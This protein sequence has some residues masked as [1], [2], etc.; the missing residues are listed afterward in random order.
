MSTWFY[1]W[2]S[3]QHYRL[4]FPEKMFGNGGIFTIQRLPSVFAPESGF[5]HEWDAGSLADRFLKKFLFRNDVS[6]WTFWDAIGLIL[7]PTERWCSGLFRTSKKSKKI[8][9]HRWKIFETVGVFEKNV[10]FSQPMFHSCSNPDSRVDHC[11]GA[12]RTHAPAISG[13]ENKINGSDQTA[14]TP[15]TKKQRGHADRDDSQMYTSPH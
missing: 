1:W 2:F 10:F 13:T 8:L 4:R 7:D 9:S 14:D 6:F 3:N 11:A 12:T 15:G 5:E